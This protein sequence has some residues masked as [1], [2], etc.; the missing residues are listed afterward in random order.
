[1]YTNGALPGAVKKKLEIQF[2]LLVHV[3][4]IIVHIKSSHPNFEVIVNVNR[5]KVFK[6]KVNENDVQCISNVLVV[7][8]ESESALNNMGRVY[9]SV[10][11]ITF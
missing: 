8:S 4:Y 10:V 9:S 5:L 7:I 6:V 1:M 11:I 3:L 2:R